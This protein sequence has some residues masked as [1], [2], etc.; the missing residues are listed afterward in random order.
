MWIFH[1]LALDEMA[2]SSQTVPVSQPLL[3]LL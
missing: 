2:S 3:L 1:R